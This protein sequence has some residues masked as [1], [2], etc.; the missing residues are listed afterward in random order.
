M[1][2]ALMTLGL[3]LVTTIAVA[4]PPAQIPLQGLLRDNAGAPVSEGAFEMTFS[5]Y[6]SADALD[7]VWTETRGAADGASC[8][9]DAEGCVAVKGGQFRIQLGAVSPLNSALFST[10]AGG[11]WLGVSV[12]G[13][14]ELPRRPLGSTPY[15]MVAGDATGL[16]CTGCISPAAL[17]DEA[18]A[19]IGAEAIAAITSAGYTQS[20]GIDYDGSATGLGAETVSEAI[21]ELK[22]LIDE[23]ATNPASSGAV[24]EG[25]GTI[26]RIANQWG[27]P[28]Y[29][30]AVEYVHLMNPTPPKVLLHLYG[31]EN[32]GFAS[33]NN[34]VVSNNYQ[35]N[36]SSGGANGVA[37]DD[38]LTVDNAGAFNAGDHI[39]IYQTVGNDPGHWELNAV[40]AINGNSLKLARNL[41][42]DY[43]DN[44]GDELRA[45][46]V[47]SSS[48]DTFEVISGG[49][50][51]PNESLGSNADHGGIVYIRARTISVKSGGVIRADGQGFDSSGS[52]GWYDWAFAGDSECSVAASFGNNNN[53]CSGGGAARTHPSY[54]DNANYGGGGGG[55]RTA[56]ES[57]LYHNSG[58]PEGGQGGAAKG[59]GDGSELHFGGAGGYS[60]AHGGYSDGGGI[61]VLGAETIIVE[62][63]GTISANGINGNGGCHAGAGG[64]A[65]GTIALFAN[66]FEL[67]GTIE[68]KGGNGGDS[69]GSAD[70]GKGGDGWI[71]ELPPIPGVVN[72]SYATGVEIWIDGQEVTPAIGNPNA[73][74]EPHW[75]AADEAWGAS[76]TEPWSSG[77]LDLTNV[78]DWT[79]GEH[80]IEFKETGGAGGDLKAYL[81][82]IQTFTESTPPVNDTC[83]SPVALD[84]SEGPVVLSGT[85]EDIMGKTKATDASAGS[86]GGT[87]GPDAVYRIDLEE[88]SL[89]NVSTVSPHPI[90]LYIREGECTDGEEVY[91]A[92]GELVTTPLEPGTY[93]LWVDSDSE[94]AKGDYTLAVSLTP[95]L[96]PNNDTCETAEPLPI[97]QQGIATA[98]GS[99]LYALGQFDSFCGGGPGADVVYSFTAEMGKVI[100]IEATSSAFQPIMYLY[101]DACGVG[102]PVFCS[103]TGTLDTPPQAGG[104]YWLVIDGAEEKDWGAFDLTISIQ[105]P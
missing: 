92:E 6:E 59:V 60:Y 104:D 105:N 20:S 15:A 23:V 97:S 94:M 14:P 91:C 48:Y 10:S 16:S 11:L 51:T 76:G 68:A 17:S 78:A 65:G 38:T 88:R 52:N 89:V 90:R 99:N 95:A 8:L 87:G 58:A 55:N 29:G 79:L 63:G 80:K 13:E 32:T 19:A 2:R 72:Q 34:L 3:S 54:C 101:K 103:F 31:G 69:Y 86:C 4:A 98:S 75:D 49:T 82:L 53:N 22:S 1:N 102:G 57:G 74:G 24:N 45:Q 9:D 70:G 18:M 36:A 100:S 47:I 37:G 33:S 26:S 5:L 77:P 56:G 42:H 28:S 61:I 73:K 21:A 27:L 93:F 81:Y 71:L 83:T 96:L 62:A 84:F 7:P 43:Q 41:E 25:A 35:P 50:V 12:E 40:Q 64:G 66:N 44:G 85:T 46:V 30:S 39:L 67:E